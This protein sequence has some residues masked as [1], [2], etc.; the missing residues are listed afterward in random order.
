MINP[1]TVIGFIDTFR[2]WSNKG[3][4]GKGIINSAAA[5]ALGRMLNKMCQK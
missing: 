4:T 3:I 1:I 5:S 2:K